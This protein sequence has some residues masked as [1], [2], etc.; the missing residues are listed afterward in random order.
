MVVF[1]A[2]NVYRMDPRQMIQQH[3][4]TGAGVTVAGIPVPRHEADQFGV[5]QVADDGL[6]IESFLEKLSDPPGIP[7]N[8]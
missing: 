3:I 6:R 2:D 7:G 5:I 1:G 8:P 4:D